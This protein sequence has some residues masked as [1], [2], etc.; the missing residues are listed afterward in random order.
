MVLLI[1]QAAM[2]KK[3]R[4]LSQMSRG[5]RMVMLS[6]NRRVQDAA[7]NSGFS[8]V[9]AVLHRRQLETC[10]SQ[11]AGKRD[12]PP[13]F[14]GLAP[15]EGRT[16]DSSRMVE[17]EVFSVCSL[18]DEQVFANG[19]LASS[20]RCSLVAPE[21]AVELDRSS[22]MPTAN[23]DTVGDAN[24]LAGP[25]D[26]DGA[27]VDGAVPSSA[28]GRKRKRARCADSTSVSQEKHG[29]KPGCGGLC[30]RKCLSKFS[31]E[32][33]ENINREF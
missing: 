18:Q 6:L 7:R 3:C 24:H 11:S 14:S 30:K 33:R 15:A 8:K 25:S 10:A 27:T 23:K 22:P 9:A 12:G 4:P 20:S 32:I 1:T 5:Q 16:Q 29:V 19:I 21:N 26:A 17:D 2:D 28:K 13:T 31:Q